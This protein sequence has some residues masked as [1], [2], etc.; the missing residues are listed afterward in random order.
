MLFQGITFLRGCDGRFVKIGV[1]A[2]CVGRICSF[3]LNGTTEKRL[4]LSPKLFATATLA[5]YFAAFVLLVLDFVILGCCRLFL[6][7]V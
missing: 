4:Y 5:L 6:S 7:L 3:L 1:R 2:V